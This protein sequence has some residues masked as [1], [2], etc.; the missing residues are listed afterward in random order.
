MSTTK[1][2]ANLKTLQ[3]YFEAMATG[4]RET[5]MSYYHPE[6]VLIVPGHHPASGRY[7]GLDGIRQFGSAMA[8]ATGGSFTVVP[9]DLIA[10]DDHGVTIA[11]AHAEV[12]GESLDWER[13]VI[14][15]FKD[16]KLVHMRF[17]ESDQEAIDALLTRS[18]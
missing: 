16:R 11:S 15:R 2:D 12:A 3:A 13:I 14:S 4:D 5:A 10:S 17:F 6:V 9:V 8:Q 7:E 18:A 1:K